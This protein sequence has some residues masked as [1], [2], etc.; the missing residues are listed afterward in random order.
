[1]VSD[2][3][4]WKRTVPGGSQATASAGKSGR[5]EINRL[6]HLEDGAKGNN[7]LEE[8]LLAYSLLS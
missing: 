4:M 8:V 3:D 7:Q 6:H 1:M 2:L 5:T